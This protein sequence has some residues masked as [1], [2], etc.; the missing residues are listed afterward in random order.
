MLKDIKFFLCDLNEDL[1]SEWKLIFG[2]YDNFHFH[3]EDIL[4]VYERLKLTEDSVGLV[5]PANSF[6]K[7]S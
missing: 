7:I 3:N 6:G 4:Q 1:I 5:S 2:D